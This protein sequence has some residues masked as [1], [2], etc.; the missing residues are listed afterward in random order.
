MTI[1]RYPGPGRML[2]Q[3][4]TRMLSFLRWLFSDFERVSVLS[5][6]MILAALPVSAADQGVEKT[7]GGWIIRGA[8]TSLSLDA[9]NLAML[10]RSGGIE[11][12]I[13]PSGRDDITLGEAGTRTSEKG[14]WRSS[15]SLSQATRVEFKPFVTGYSDGLRLEVSGFKREDQVLDSELT[16]SVEVERE[17]GDVIFNAVSREGRSVV[18][19]LRWPRGFVPGSADATVVPFM[20]GMFLPKNWPRKVSLYDS[21]AYGRGLYMPWWGQQQGESAAMIIL[22]T[23]ADGGCRFEHPAGG[24]TRIEPRWLHSL[25]KFA[26]PRQLRMCFFEKGNY[27]D[28]ALRYRQHALGNGTLVTLREKFA[29]NP[30]ASRL[31]G[32]PVVHT[33]ILSHIQ[34][35]SS[36]YSKDNPAANHQL[37]T[38]DQRAAELRK[39]HMAGVKRAYVH[40]DGWGF[41][42]Y[43]N[44]HPDIL[45][46]SPE[47]GGWEGL[48]RFAQAC[49]DLGY[50]FAVH[51]QY[52]DFYHDAASYREDLTVIQEDGSRPFG[53][54][55]WGGK[56]SILCSHF[57][58]GYVLRNHRTI[59]GQG[60]KLRGAYLDVF[61]V[62]PGD[63]CYSSEHPVT[64]AESLRLRGQ[65]FDVIRDLEGVVSS[66]EPADW[67]MRYLHLVH[68]GPFALDPN[69]GKG[70]AMGVPVPLHALVYHDALV[71][72]WSLSKGGWGIPDEDFG[73]LY[74]LGTAGVP[75]VSLAPG[76][77]EMN[78]VRTVCALHR[79]LALVPMTR[80]EFLDT[81]FRR[82]KTT[83]ADGTTVEADF[84]TGKYSIAPVLT[85][86]E[87]DNVWSDAPEG[88]RN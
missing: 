25:G 30:I 41:R 68:H 48:R 44:L 70:P 1:L 73:L 6:V 63:E 69:P 81:S 36:Y 40:L 79:R 59:L 16:L 86:R 71:T 24:P 11:W 2:V 46:P 54:I 14:G 31:M 88:A 18:K 64:R 21:L 49:E 72:P 76:A 47:A 8:K 38:F 60:V 9:T 61:A 77:E 87:L 62:V 43:D 20:Q 27:V 35:E 13:E 58:P 85:S 42:G 75:Y 28:M 3:S 56:Q 22:E 84:E 17:S 45:P 5:S 37:V 78:Q 12:R 53:Q 26:Y 7:A 80:H 55:W 10:V 34:P 52:R 51:D 74:A 29:R 65:C 67:A 83:F 4:M 33:T 66:E 23:P 82:Q 15:Y 32:S 19:E 50:L 57:A 39:L